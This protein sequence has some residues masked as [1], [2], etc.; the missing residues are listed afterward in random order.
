MIR[1][2]KHYAYHHDNRDVITQ[3]VMETFEPEDPVL[4]DI[5]EETLRLKMPAI[6][7]GPMDARHLEVLTQM[8]GARKTLEIGTLTGYSGVCLLRGMG[9]EGRLI[10]LEKRPDRAEVAKNLFEKHGYRPQVDVRVGDALRLLPD[11][12]SEAPFDLVFIDADKVHYPDYLDWAHRLLRKGGV[13]IA[14]NTFV[15]GALPNKTFI[16]KVDQHTIQGVQNLNRNIARDGRF[17]AT[18]FPTSE[19]LTVGVKL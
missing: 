11:L 15:Y 2:E 17:K 10:T 1:K 12:Q 18:L 14:D 7:L 4:L 5:R 3:W 6:Y 9:P 13:V 19:G 16:S 8:T